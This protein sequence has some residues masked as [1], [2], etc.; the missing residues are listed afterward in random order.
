MKRMLMGLMVLVCVVGSGYAGE[1]N[2]E[3]VSA[4]ARW[5]AH[6][7]LA[8][9]QKTQLGKYIWKRLSSDAVERK[10]AAFAAIF[11]ADPR[12]DLTS[13]TVYGRDA[14]PRSA[15]LFIQGTFDGKRLTTLVKANDTYTSSTY[16]ADHVLHSWKETRHNTIQTTHGTLLADNTIVISA[17]ADVLKAALDVLD[18]RAKNVG[19]GGIVGDVAALGGRPFFVAVAKLEG[20]P[21]GSP[22]A[23]IL[24]D[25]TSA[26]VVIDEEEGRLKAAMALEMV[27][28]AKANQMVTM[29]NGL[30]AF[31]QMAATK[32]PEIGK[33]A[34]AIRI[35]VN[36][37][38]FKATLSYPVVDLI[39]AM[40]DGFRKFKEGMKKG[41]GG[42]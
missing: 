18:G 10:I 35:S 8:G 26:R 27:D 9:F 2:P 30:V 5:V 34:A 33:L 31:G 4:D 12:K 32:N 15:V 16:G 13:L 22:N 17:S 25:A 20:L 36:E 6:L 29:A 11:N 14:T 7:D 37:A 28:A 3:R 39:S 41:G 21:G 40:E 38:T 42:L 1:F 23:A 19:S 24:K